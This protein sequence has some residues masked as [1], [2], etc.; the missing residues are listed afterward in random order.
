MKK[1]FVT[2]EATLLVTA[3]AAASPA[4][5][6]RG[7][8]E[9][10]LPYVGPAYGVSVSTPM[11]SSTL[12]G[13]CDPGTAQPPSNGCVR[14]PVK[15]GDSYLSLRIDDAT[16]LPVLGAAVD[17]NGEVLGLF[18]GATED[19]FRIPSGAAFVDVWAVAGNCPSVAQ[20]S[21]PT[22]GTITATFSRR[23]R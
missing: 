22:T 21:V 4:G 16:K 5:V 15:R 13:Y 10:A 17:S 7:A 3:G 1:L 14:F 19:P 12:A 6:A 11:P 8:R 20:P 9:T 2:I 23:S 18:C